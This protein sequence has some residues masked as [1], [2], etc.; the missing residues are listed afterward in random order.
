M[1]AVG[2]RHHP[3]LVWSIVLEP[4]LAIALRRRVVQPGEGLVSSGA[5]RGMVTTI[6][7]IVLS[8][9]AVAPDVAPLPCQ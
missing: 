2:D 1:V 5:G 6:A 3:V 4:E 7:W 8:V 9:R